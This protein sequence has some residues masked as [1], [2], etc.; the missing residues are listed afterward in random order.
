MPQ[1]SIKEWVPDELAKI[2]LRLTV[3]LEGCLA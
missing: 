3:N 2:H 1:A